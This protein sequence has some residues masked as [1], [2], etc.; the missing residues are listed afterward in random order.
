MCHICFAK[1]SLDPGLQVHAGSPQDPREG[2]QRRQREGR[3][4]DKSFSLAQRTQSQAADGAESQAMPGRPGLC[5]SVPE[6][7][8]V[9]TLGRLAL[10]LH[11]WGHSG[12][13][14]HCLRGSQRQ[15]PPPTAAQRTML[16]MNGSFDNTLD[17]AVLPREL[18]CKAVGGPAGWMSR[19]S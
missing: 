16:A 3:S 9:I 2:Q 13:C 1:R 8:V 19:P 11:C 5:V 17:T 7:T 18:P 14:W 4:S 12:A 6:D 15:L 10:N